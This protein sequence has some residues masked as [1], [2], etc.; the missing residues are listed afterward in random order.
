MYASKKDDLCF[1]VL[2]VFA[3]GVFG[4]HCV[5][6]KIYHN[7]LSVIID[8]TIN[9][10]HM[11]FTTQSLFAISF[12]ASLKATHNRPQYFC[13]AQINSKL[14]SVVHQPKH[15]ESN[16]T[17]AWECLCHSL[18]EAVVLTCSLTKGKNWT[19]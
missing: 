9:L 7:S 17:W 8:K 15:G 10:T 3:F 5:L 11:Q 14:V 18:S 12:A 1:F 4:G 2:F 19:T 6:T 13:P 16:G